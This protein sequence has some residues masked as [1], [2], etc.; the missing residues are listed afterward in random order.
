MI[1]DTLQALTSEISSLKTRAVVDDEMLEHLLAIYKI[2]YIEG[3]YDPLNQRSEEA[4]VQ[5]WPH[6]KAINAVLRFKK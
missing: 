4:A 2:A 5:I 3:S 6:I 1:D